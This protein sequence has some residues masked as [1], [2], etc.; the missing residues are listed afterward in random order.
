MEKRRKKGK[1]DQGQFGQNNQPGT[2][3]EATM[4]ASRFSSHQPRDGSEMM[5]T[6]AYLRRVH[7]R[8]QAE[9]MLVRRTE[10]QVASNNVSLF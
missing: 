1:G 10:G 2:S 9:V 8:A 4:N 5:S 3:E 6:V 7:D